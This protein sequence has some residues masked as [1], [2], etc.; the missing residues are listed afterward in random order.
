MSG[1]AVAGQRCTKASIA[2][3][4]SRGAFQEQG[5]VFMYSVRATAS[6]I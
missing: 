4:L 6:Q 1:I 2:V 5:V 3:L